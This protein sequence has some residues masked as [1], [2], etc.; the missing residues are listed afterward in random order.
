MEERPLT[1]NTQESEKAAKAAVVAR[2]LI[3]PAAMGFGAL[4]VLNFVLVLLAVVLASV[5]ILT[6]AMGTLYTLG[7]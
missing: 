4:F 3:I 6:A 1:E 7:A 2:C 5:G